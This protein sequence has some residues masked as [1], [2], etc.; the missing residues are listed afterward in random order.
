LI[1]ALTIHFA[2][3]HDFDEGQI[4]ATPVRP[5]NERDKFILIEILQGDRIDLDLQSGLLR[6]INAFE[7]L[8]EIAPTCDGFET[9]V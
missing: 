5:A 4:H 8:V 6:S 3:G 9:M 1:D 7:N 2:H